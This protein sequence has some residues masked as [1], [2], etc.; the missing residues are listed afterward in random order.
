ML[1]RI[2][3][4]AA[5]QRFNLRKL[6]RHS[7]SSSLGQPQFNFW[8]RFHG[9]ADSSRGNRII[10]LSFISQIRGPVESPRQDHY[11][12]MR[13]KQSRAALV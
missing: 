4:W 8:T 13:P 9:R 10:S 1:V 6:Q 12:D 2:A 11:L 3:E 7:I 5:I